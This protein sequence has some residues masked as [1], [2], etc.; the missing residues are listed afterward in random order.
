MVFVTL[1]EDGGAITSY[2]PL[3]DT[4][5]KA[6]EEA[7]E[8]VRFGFTSAYVGEAPSPSTD[9]LDDWRRSKET[10]AKMKARYG[11]DYDYVVGF[12][13]W[14]GG[15]HRTRIGV[16]Q[17][18]VVSRAYREVFRGPKEGPLPLRFE[19]DAESLGSHDRGAAPVTIDALY[20]TCA[21]EWLAERANGSKVLFQADTDGLLK[22]CSYSRPGCADDCNVGV[23][24]DRIEWSD[25]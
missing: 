9:I 2:T 18:K 7:P 24:I 25:R 15:V 13:S 3:T 14:A 21:D 10:W 4:L 20:E 12:Y 5:E 19:E 23:S 16:R 22:H 6:L 11:K 17:G 8:T 1:S